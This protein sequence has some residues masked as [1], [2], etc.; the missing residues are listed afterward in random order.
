MW[1]HE[2]PSKVKTFKANL[3]RAGTGLDCDQVLTTP[4]NKLV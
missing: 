1:C 4:V 3:S 2:R